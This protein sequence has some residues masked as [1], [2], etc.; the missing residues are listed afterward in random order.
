MT[1][2]SA[3]FANRP[4][5]GAPGGASI[6]SILDGAEHA[7]ARVHHSYVAL[8]TPMGSFP[9]AAAERPLPPP[10]EIRNQEP[11]RSL[12]QPV[13]WAWHWTLHRAIR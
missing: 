11:G 8:G 2:D 3:L 9:G 13:P 10:V 6:A 1:F 7:A 5:A 12:R 4:G